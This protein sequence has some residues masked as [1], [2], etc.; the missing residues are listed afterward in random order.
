MILVR[1]QNG[2]ECGSTRYNTCALSL[3]QELIMDFIHVKKDKKYLPL[4]GS[5]ISGEQMSDI[6]DQE[7]VCRTRSTL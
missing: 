7:S 4:E 3:K 5:H 6:N 2:R 1:S